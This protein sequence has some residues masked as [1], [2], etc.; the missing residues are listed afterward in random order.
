MGAFFMN[1]FCELTNAIFLAIISI[2]FML[3]ERINR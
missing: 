3:P 1:E 2:F